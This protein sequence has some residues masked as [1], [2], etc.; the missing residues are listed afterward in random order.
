[1][2]EFYRQMYRVEATNVIDAIKPAVV[3]PFDA[4]GKFKPTMKLLE[5]V[6]KA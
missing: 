1:M 4:R 5:E 3:G 2:H 6:R